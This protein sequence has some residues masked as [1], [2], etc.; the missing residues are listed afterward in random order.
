MYPGRPTPTTER[1]QGSGVDLARAALCWSE[2][3]VEL[4]A[5][6]NNPTTSNTASVRYNGGYRSSTRA[7]QA[8]ESQ[9]QEGLAQE[10]RCH[11]DS[12]W[13]RGCARPDHPRA[14]SSLTTHTATYTNNSTVV[15]S[16]KRRPMSSSP[17]ISLDLPKF[18][19]RLRNDTSLS[20]STRSSPSA[21]P[22]PPYPQGSDYRKLP[23][24]ARERRQRYQAR[25]TTG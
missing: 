9:R 25:N 21:L 18:K 1:L 16:L 3:W 8:A 10:R 17:S 24:M 11:A 23:T 13:P 6:A 12:V 15:S 2:F 7:V 22:F 19:R 5:T 4:F 14:C 20:K